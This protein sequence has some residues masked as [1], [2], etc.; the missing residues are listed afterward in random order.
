MKR[1]YI[2][3]VLVV[4]TK[5]LLIAQDTAFVRTFGGIN[6]DVAR[7]VKECENLGFIIAGTT[8]SFGQGNTSMYLVKTDSLGQH[9]W[10]KNYG[11]LNSDW[12]Y[13]VET[14]L[15]NGFLISGFSNS[16]SND[17][18]PFVVKTDNNGNLLW[19]KVY[20]LN[21]WDFIYGSVSLPDSSFILC[22]ETY[23]DAI[24]GAD[25]LLMRIDKLGNLIWMKNI[26][27]NADDKLQKV[28]YL[29]NTIYC[30]GSSTSNSLKNGMLVK[31]DLNGN[32][33]QKFFYTFNTSANQEL[34]G[35]ASNSLNELIMAGYVNPNGVNDINDWLIKVDTSG[36]VTFNYSA[37]AGTNGTKQFNDII[38]IDNDEIITTGVN[39]GGNGGLGVF[40]VRYNSGGV[41]IAA[42][43]FGGLNNEYGYA[44]T[45]TSNKHIAFVGSTESFTCGDQDMYFIMN[46]NQHFVSNSRLKNKYFCDTLDLAIVDLKNL[47]PILNTINYFPNPFN[48]KLTIEINESPYKHE[49]I[50]FLLKDLSGRL[51]YTSEMKIGS[52]E[53]TLD[54][55]NQGMYFFEIIGDA[56]TFATGKLIHQK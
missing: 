35:I 32:N 12:A 46:R 53:I 52:N 10:S 39:N 42:D 34:N 15:D 38:I 21:D 28:I 8:S 20:P 18:D 54:E 48:D 31:L 56:N 45:L 13:S 37:P 3:I 43:N 22:G 25:G 16:F 55:L 6:M 47:D 4:L 9:I 7:D 2:Y 41:Y 1:L 19:Q 29:N 5:S 11:G 50:M 17:Y 27:T 49:K 23:S 30:V 26:G 51:I 24:G 40:M 14:T 44:V 33:E 36:N